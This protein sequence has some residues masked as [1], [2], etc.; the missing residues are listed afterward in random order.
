MALSDFKND[1]KKRIPVD[2]AEVF[3]ILDRHIHANSSIKNDIAILNGQYNHLKRE[4]TMGRLS[5]EEFMRLESQKWNSLMNLID[6]VHPDDM[7][8]KKP[9]RILT[10]CGNE[11]DKKYMEQYFE[12]LPFEADVFVFNETFSFEAYSLIVFDNHNTGMIR[13]KEDI[14]KAAEDKKG[15]LKLMQ[16]YLEKA[17]KWI[18]HFGEFNYL[19]NDYREVTNAANNKFSLYNCL[20][21]MKNFIED[22]QVGRT[23]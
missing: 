10:I 9:F 2:A 18:V 1:L 13:S 15:L 22:Y 8:E 19:L 21:Y 11:V 7:L 16:E 3:R 5:Y 17:P 6:T 20:N 14:A 4:H 12:A 23:K